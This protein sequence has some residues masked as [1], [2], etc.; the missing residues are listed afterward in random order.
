MAKASVDRLSRNY[1]IKKYF[2]LNTTKCSKPTEYC[3]FHFSTTKTSQQKRPSLHFHTC[4]RMRKLIFCRKSSPTD[5]SIKMLLKKAIVRAIPI[6]CGEWE[7]SFYSG[8]SSASIWP[9]L[10]FGPRFAFFSSSN[11][12][13]NL[14]IRRNSRFMEIISVNTCLYSR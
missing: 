7:L 1:T 4:N 10:L 12:I 6:F 3:L 9:T 8:T 5:G 14:K 2:F 11:E 13:E